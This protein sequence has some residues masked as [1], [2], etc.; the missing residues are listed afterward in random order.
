MIRKFPSPNTYRP[1]NGFSLVEIAISTAIIGTLS[2]I[3]YP[4]YTNANNSAKLADAKAKML[5]IP[6]IIGQHIDE[7]GE[8]PTTWD[9]LSS[10]AAV[11]TSNGPATGDLNTPITLPNSIYDLSITGPTESVYTMTATRVSDR[12]KEE[13][14][15]DETKYTYAIKSCFNISNGASDLRSGNLSEIENTI[16]CG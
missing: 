15:A 5:V 8:A 2:S 7:T 4:S 11:M 3:A 16:N 12:E 14:N 6:A 13:E 9:E 10:I 1:K